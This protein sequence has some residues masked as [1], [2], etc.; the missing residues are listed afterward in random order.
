MA[1]TR[2]YHQI[3]VLSTYTDA[4]EVVWV[5]DVGGLSLGRVNCETGHL[6]IKLLVFKFK[7]FDYNTSL[8]HLKFVL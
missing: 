2:I 3:E 4:L 6:Y 8:I 5:G 1:Y 7:F